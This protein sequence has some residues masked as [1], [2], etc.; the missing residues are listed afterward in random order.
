[1]YVMIQLEELSTHN[2]LPRIVTNRNIHH[3]TTQ[4]VDEKIV[5]SIKCLNIGFTS[6]LNQ[7]RFAENNI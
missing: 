7:K 2:T 3:H 1:M 4:L 5:T 6:K